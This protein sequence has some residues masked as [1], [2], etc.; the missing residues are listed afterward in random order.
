M[1]RICYLHNPGGLNNQKWALFGLFVAGLGTGRPMVLPDLY[2]LDHRRGSGRAVPIGSV[3][4]QA[5]LLAVAERYGITVLDAPP[6]GDPGGWRGGGSGCF[7]S[8]TS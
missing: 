3:L 1:T 5:P 6:R 2:V 8:P 7:P 4:D